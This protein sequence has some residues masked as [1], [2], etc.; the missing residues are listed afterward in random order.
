M[1]LQNVCLRY[2]SIDNEFYRGSSIQKYLEIMS[3]INMYLKAED[4]RIISKSFDI[5]NVCTYINRF[6]HN[7]HLI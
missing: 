3:N 7:D 2:F 5:C 1:C 4:I 6:G